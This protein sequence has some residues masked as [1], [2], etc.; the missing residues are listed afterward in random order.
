[1]VIKRFTDIWKLEFGFANWQVQKMKLWYIIWRAVKKRINKGLSLLSRKHFI[2]GFDKKRTERRK[3]A[4]RIM[5]AFKR[6]LA[7]VKSREVCFSNLKIHQLTRNKISKNNALFLCNSILAVKSTFLTPGN[8]KRKESDV[9]E[10]IW[11]RIKPN[12][13]KSTAWFTCRPI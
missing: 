13:D 3:P 8:T 4:L 11:E 12:G 1:M 10:R 7:R 9:F 2:V 6:N 5:N